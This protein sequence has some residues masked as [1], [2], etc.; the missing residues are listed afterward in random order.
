MKKLIRFV[1]I[2][3]VLAGALALTK[4]GTKSF[5]TWVKKEAV[6]KRSQPKGDDLVEKLVDKGVTTAA[7]LQIL[8]TYRYTDHKLI[9]LVEAHANGK[10]IT[11]LGIATF[12]IP[13]PF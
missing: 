7:Q 1:V 6:E 2:L 9:A 3:L 13:I 11:F 12:W 4:P 10:K 8:A 5:E